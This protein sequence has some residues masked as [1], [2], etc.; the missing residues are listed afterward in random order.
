MKSRSKLGPPKKAP[1]WL[2]ALRYRLEQSWGH[3]VQPWVQCKRNKKKQ[4]TFC[5][6]CSACRANL[7]LS[8][9]EDNYCVGDREVLK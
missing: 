3:C 1:D 2:L 6:S 7:A 5:F 9:L 8:I 4:D